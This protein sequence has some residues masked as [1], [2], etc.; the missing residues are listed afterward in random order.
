MRLRVPIT[1]YVEVDNKNEKRAIADAVAWVQ[2]VFEAGAASVEGQR[3]RHC[4]VSIR[5]KLTHEIE[6]HIGPD[7]DE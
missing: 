6:S 1:L 7:N 3:I 4:E 5:E 2:N